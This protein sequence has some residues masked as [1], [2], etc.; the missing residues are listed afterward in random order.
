M[1]R[2]PLPIPTIS[3]GNINISENDRDD[4]ENNSNCS[5]TEYPK[6]RFR[7]NQKLSLIVAD[8]QFDRAEEEKG[9]DLYS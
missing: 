5:E 3:C 8:L 9:E 4:L 2:I 7:V 6:R 1:A